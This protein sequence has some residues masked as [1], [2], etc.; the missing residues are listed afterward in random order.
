M[1]ELVESQKILRNRQR[2]NERQREQCVTF[3][4]VFWFVFL[5]A[6]KS[7]ESIKCVLE[8]ERERQMETER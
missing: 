8:R 6:S 4:K 3:R 7:I 2:T 5:I 1:V